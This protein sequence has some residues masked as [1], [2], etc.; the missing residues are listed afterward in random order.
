[1]SKVGKAIVFPFMAVNMSCSS[2]YQ[3]N[4]TIKEMVVLEKKKTQHCNPEHLFSTVFFPLVSFYNLH[5]KHE[6]TEFGRLGSV[7]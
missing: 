2:A 1:M 3:I 6:V 5:P 4:E 7:Q